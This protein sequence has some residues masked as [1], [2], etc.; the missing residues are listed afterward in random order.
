M[1]ILIYFLRNFKF[2]PAKSKELSWL[3]D[4]AAMATIV[5]TITSCSTTTRLTSSQAPKINQVSQVSQA[6][7]QQNPAQP[8]QWQL[9]TADEQEQAWK[10]ILNSPLGI[11]A[12]N[13]LA[14]EGFISPNCPKTFYLNEEYGGFQTLLRVRCPTARGVS[15]ALDYEEMRIIFNR[16]E[17]NI[18]D[19]QVERISFPEKT[20]TT[21]LPD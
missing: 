19:F 18:E 16:F 20:P 2:Y 5:V 3:I 7:T 12:L 1:K 17:D 21:P 13:Q 15:T 10:Y 11:A 8:R 4:C 6:S 14:I 9:M